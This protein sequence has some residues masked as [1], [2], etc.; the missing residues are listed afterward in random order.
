[1]VT[2][3]HSRRRAVMLVELT[4]AVAVLVIVMAGFSAAYYTDAKALRATYCR[5]VAIE[6]VDGEFEA[7]LAGEWQAY[8]EGAHDYKPR[9]DAAANLPDGAFAL[10]IE[11]KSIRLEWLP[12]QQG[13][14][15]RVVREATLP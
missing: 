12:A 1:M 11:G 14:G 2:P 10:T 4:V 9:A 3:P 6:I 5:A 15:G 13:K 7:L 8:G